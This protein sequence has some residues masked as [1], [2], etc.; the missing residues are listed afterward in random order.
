MTVAPAPAAVER[1]ADE[2]TSAAFAYEAL[3]HGIATCRL[4]PGTP[5]RERSD[6]ARLGM[7]RTPFRE[8]LH[9]L[10]LEGLVVRRPKRG[11]SVAPLSAR[12]VRE[13]M[14]LRE[15][16][17]VTMAQHLVAAG[18]PDLSAPEAMLAQQRGALGGGDAIGFLEADEGFHLV[19]VQL[20]G[21]A[22]AVE[23]ARRAWLHV[24]RARYLA[25]MA[26]PAMQ[27]ALRDHE[28]ILQALRAG[29]V[30][31]VRWAIRRHLDE[32][33]EHQLEDLQ[34]KHPEAFAQ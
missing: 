4:W 9:R 32:P 17:E 27:A 15:A 13:H 20:A 33:L 10:E 8:A 26:R 5:I 24:N 2:A 11:T 16:V 21:N 25:P 7:S 19:L 31:R 23:T 14:V 18:A 6:A 30:D 28:E 29:D 3:A 22:A 1:R 34:A 12:D